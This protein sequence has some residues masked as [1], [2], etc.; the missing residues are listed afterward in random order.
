MDRVAGASPAAPA[1]APALTRGLSLGALVALVVGNQLGTSLYTLPASVANAAGPLGVISWLVAALGFYLLAEVFAQLG[2]RFPRTG[3]PYVFAERAFGRFVGFQ[4]AWAYW[5][6]VWVGNVAIVT[7][8]VAYVGFFVPAIDQVPWIRFLTAQALLWGTCW[9]NVRGV[10]ESG[11]VQLGLLL[12]NLVPFVL[13]A[14]A[15]R[16]FNPANFTPFAPKGAPGMGAGVVLLVW[17]FSGIESAVVTAGEVAGGTET[18]RRGT[19]LGFALAATMFILAAVVVTGVL[20][21]SEIGATPRPL[22]LVMERALGPWAGTTIAV[23]GVVTAFACLNGWTLLVGRIPFSAAEDGVFPAA[24]AR[25]HPRYGTPAFGLVAGTALA[26]VGLLTYFSNSLLQAFDKLVL[27]A[28]FAILLIYAASA[29][30]AVWL[31]WRPGVI[32]PEPERLR[33]RLVGVGAFAFLAWATANVGIET[34][35]W[36]SLVVVLGVPL[37]ILKTRAR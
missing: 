22:L 34:V 8:V 18:I 31:A 7:G 27:L 20:P 26:S 19:R 30:A 28:N 11:R 36:G 14:L 1:S 35:T 4:T 17:A 23:L 16:A 32:S 2:P 12:L 29:A 15:L 37:Y 24:F 5:I 25:V 10:R 3:G 13:L 33:L 21:A 9:L 6:S